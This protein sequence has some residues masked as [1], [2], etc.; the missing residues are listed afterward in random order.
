MITSNEAEIDRLYDEFVVSGEVVAVQTRG[1]LIDIG[2]VVSQ[3]T[4]NRLLENE[5]IYSMY[6]EAGMMGV[7][8]VA[9]GHA[10]FNELMIFREEFGF[11]DWALSINDLEAFVASNMPNDLDGAVGVTI[12]SD[13][14]GDFS[15]NLGTGFDYADFTFGERQRVVPIILH[16]SFF[17]R[18]D[19][20]YG[21]Y[22]HLV[23]ARLNVSDVRII[24]S[25]SGGLVEGI[26]RF[27]RPMILMSIDGMEFIAR[28]L[29]YNTVR[30]DVNT[31]FNRDLHRFREE[32]WGIVRASGAGLVD[33]ELILGDDELRLVIG[34][35]EQ[36]LLLLQLLYP[37]ALIVVTILATGLA[38]LILLQNA[39][40]AA[41]MR[42][43]G[44]KK[45]LVRLML[46][47]E[48]LTI[49]MLGISLGVLIMP[50]FG[51]SPTA[52]TLYI[53]ALY[54]IGASAGAITGSIFNTNRSIL[55]LLQVR[56]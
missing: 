5:F 13:Y 1:N 33:L 51:I 6:L 46:C 36:S 53:V 50:I 17:E 25:F 26:G 30:F 45:A 23:D 16:V 54:I 8:L 14:V 2:N 44:S 27:N 4:I 34:P 37:I 38:V 15:I 39:K 19:L 12:L 49:S 32:A 18:Y 3:V 56:E 41:I 11:N 29:I 7:G 28:A 52:A 9:Y 20:N 43:L 10:D 35:L 40:K 24:G 55:E 47:S 31:A 22:L 42:S 21:D 48:Y